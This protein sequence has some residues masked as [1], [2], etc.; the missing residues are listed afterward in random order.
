MDPAVP[1]AGMQPRAGFTVWSRARLALA[2]V[3]LAGIQRGA[4]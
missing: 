2:F 3:I 1:G 4:A